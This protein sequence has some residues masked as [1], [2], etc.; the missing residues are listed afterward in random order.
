MDIFILLTEVFC[1]FHAELPPDLQLSVE[2]CLEW[3]STERIFPPEGLACTQD[4]FGTYTFSVP[5]EEVEIWLS[6]ELLNPRTL[7]ITGGRIGRPP[8]DE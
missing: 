1:A 6:A 2:C 7:N 4:V 5:C 3:I 8:K